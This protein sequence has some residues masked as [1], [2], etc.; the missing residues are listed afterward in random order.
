LDTAEGA[1]LM[2]EYAKLTKMFHDNGGIEH[3][4][5]IVCQIFAHKSEPTHFFL[6]GTILN[7]DESA[8]FAAI[9][10]KRKKS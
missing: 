6:S 2:E 4:H 10:A 5:T 8:A 9:M 1:D 7:Q 3:G